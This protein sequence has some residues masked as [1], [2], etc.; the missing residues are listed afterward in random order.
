MK[1]LIKPLTT[2]P[3]LAIFM[4]AA[5]GAPPQ[6]APPLTITASGST[7]TISGVT[8][9][10]KVVFFGVARFVDRTTVTARRLDRIVTDD[11]GDGV[12]TIDLG[13]RVPWKSIF[14]AV[15][16]ASGRYGL[17]TPYQH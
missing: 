12:V 7:I 6:A 15:D 3:I 16:F 14:A 1:I 13:E 9:H 11:D 10:G 8:P 17:A 2:L 5:A 4:S